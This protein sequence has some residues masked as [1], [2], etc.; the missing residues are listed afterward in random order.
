VN[1]YNQYDALLKE[2]L[3]GVTA[4]NAYVEGT[5]S[6]PK[7]AN[8]TSA[9]HKLVVGAGL[10]NLYANN[11]TQYPERNLEDVITKNPD[12]IVKL[13]GSSTA[14]EGTTYDA[15]V[16]ELAGVAAADNGKVILLN[17]ECG[18]TAI[19]AVI[20]RLYIAKYVYPELFADVDVD[21]VYE[22]L[23]TEF[24]GKD[25]IGSGAFFK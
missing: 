11:E 6:T 14:L 22:K 5:S 19:G 16:A 3:A 15:Y 1:L 7:T 17:N 23:C 8:G 4:L 10:V 21:A 25:Y 24:F 9:A 2:R 13:C 20:G 18:T 12:V